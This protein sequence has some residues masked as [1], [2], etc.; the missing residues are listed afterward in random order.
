MMLTKRGTELHPDDRREV[1]EAYLYRMTTEAQKRWPEIARTMRAGGY[2]M[3]ERS[4]AEWLAATAFC[5]RK[6]GRLHQGVRRC[7]TT[8]S[9]A[10]E[11]V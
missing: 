7:Y 4:D 6:D 8:H 1:L 11:V 9:P 5:V 3:P 10:P 2:R